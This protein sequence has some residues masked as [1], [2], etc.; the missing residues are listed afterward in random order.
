M[1]LDYP[2][3]LRQTLRR[4]CEL[5]RQYTCIDGQRQAFKIPGLDGQTISYHKFYKTM[6]RLKPPER[7]IAKCRYMRHRCTRLHK[8]PAKPKYRQCWLMTPKTTKIEFNSDVNKTGQTGS[9]I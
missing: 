6:T 5:W 3:S 9:E 1:I 2:F 7:T 4:L 8:N